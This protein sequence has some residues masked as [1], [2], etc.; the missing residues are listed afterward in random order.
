V[1][2]LLRAELVSGNVGVSTEF[3]PK[4]RRR[5]VLMGFVSIAMAVGELVSLLVLFGASPTRLAHTVVGVAALIAVLGTT[6]PAVLSLMEQAMDVRLVNLPLPQIAWGVSVALGIAT[7]LL[8]NRLGLFAGGSR[9]LTSLEKPRIFTVY[10]TCA[11]GACGLN[12]RVAPSPLSRKI[13][14][15]Q[16]GTAIGVI[17]QTLGYRM[18]A[19]GNSSRVWDQLA[20]SAFVSDL[21]VTT[22]GSGAFSMQ[23]R[24]CPA[25]R[26][27][28]LTRG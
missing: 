17:C 25:K 1:A 2:V 24:R 19:S 12:E 9:P 23:L 10:G 7:L 28:N 27:T 20:N 11:A 26:I 13:G 4:L 14:M 8:A 15:L 3:S 6:P 18:H 5:A 22:P 16:D 21:Y